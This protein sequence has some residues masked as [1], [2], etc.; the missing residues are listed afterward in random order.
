V[1]ASRA[2]RFQ[3]CATSPEFGGK[4]SEPESLWCCQSN[5]YQPLEARSFLP[6]LIPKQNKRVADH[7][8]SERR[9]WRLIGV[10]RSAWQYAPLRGK[11][12]AVRE[13]MREIANERRWFGYRRLAILLRREG[14][15]MNLKKAYRL[16]REER[17]TVRKRGVRKRALGTRTPMAIPQ[18]P[19]QRWSLDFVSDAMACGRNSARSTSSTTIAGSAGRALSIPRCHGGVWCES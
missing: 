7:G 17:L 14:K 15:G 3:D 9:A 18:E 2:P 5:R 11:D 8:I 1:S 16:Y 13:R 10:N 4:S 12:D 19:N 6:G